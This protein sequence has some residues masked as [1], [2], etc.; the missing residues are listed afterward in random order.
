MPYAKDAE[1]ELEVNRGCVSLYASD[2][3][4]F[5]TAYA[6]SDAGAAS[7]INTFVLCNM[8]LPSGQHLHDPEHLFI[9]YSSNHNPTI[10]SPLHCSGCHKVV[11]GLVWEC[12]SVSLRSQLNLQRIL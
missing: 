4:I 10:S 8:Y 9:R 3:K 7:H 1:S 11:M 2:P 5:I 12:K 6:D